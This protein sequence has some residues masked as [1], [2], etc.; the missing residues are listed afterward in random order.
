MFVEKDLDLGSGVFATDG[1]LH[2]GIDPVT[3]T[4]NLKGRINYFIAFK[5][6]LISDGAIAGI[7]R[8]GMT[9]LPREARNALGRFTKDGRSCVSPATTDPV[10]GSE[11][12]EAAAPTIT[13]PARPTQQQTLTPAEIQEETPK[14]LG[15]ETGSDETTCALTANSPDFEDKP[16][17]FEGR[18]K[19]PPGCAS[20]EDGPVF[21]P[22]D[23]TEGPKA[24][25][26]DSSICRAALHAGKID[27]SGA[28]VTFRI[29]AGRKF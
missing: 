9:P 7:A 17:D 14:N 2:F 15:F 5:D 29:V 13:L 12:A 25:D 18:V 3:K 11:Q 10:P 16:T 6:K 28:D 20:K 22:S 21:G 19:C 26:G 1:S 24:Y 4:N 23:D 27:D 8:N